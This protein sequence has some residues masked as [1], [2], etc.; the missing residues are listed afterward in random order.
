MYCRPFGKRSNHGFRLFFVLG[1][2]VLFPACGSVS[3][4]D[5]KADDTLRRY[6]DGQRWIEVR[7]LLDVF[8]G[9]AQ[10]R[11]A[12]RKRGTWVYLDAL[13]RWVSVAHSKTMARHDDGLRNPT[14][15]PYLPTSAPMYPSAEPRVSPARSWCRST[16]L[17]IPPVCWS[18]TVSDLDVHWITCGSRQLGDVKDAALLALFACADAHRQEAGVALLCP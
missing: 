4:S 3:S 2:C 13:I 14:F 15:V 9:R 11:T 7:V 1:C 17:L 18:A 16:I 12:A 10:A 6:H 8:L 5:P